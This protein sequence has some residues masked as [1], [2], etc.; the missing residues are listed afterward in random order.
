MAQKTLPP[1]PPVAPKPNR[2]EAR[3]QAIIFRMSES[4]NRTMDRQIFTRLLDYLDAYRP[5]SCPLNVSGEIPRRPTQTAIVLAGLVRAIRMLWA[6]APMSE[7]EGVIAHLED[8]LANPNQYKLE[9]DIG[10]GYRLVKSE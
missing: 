8:I 4:S 5:G 3:L 6:K 1:L 2:F 10:L 9:G 7:I